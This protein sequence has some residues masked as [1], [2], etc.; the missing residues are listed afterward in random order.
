MT[1]GY[2]SGLLKRSTRFGSGWIRGKLLSSWKM[3]SRFALSLSLDSYTHLWLESY[4]YWGPDAKW[5]C[6]GDSVALFRS[7]AGITKCPCFLGGF[8]QG[9][10]RQAPKAG[11]VPC[12]YGTGV[13]ATKRGETNAKEVNIVLQYI[14]TQRISPWI[15]TESWITEKPGPQALTQG[16]R[17]TSP[18]HYLPMNLLI[19]LSS[20]K[21]PLHVRVRREKIMYL[22]RHI[23]LS[24]IVYNVGSRST[25]TQTLS[26]G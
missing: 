10:A 23:L 8:H 22:I 15:F 17:Q 25:Q 5:V 13:V 6:E 11:E 20:L 7:Q 2:A 9:G 21:N 12:R 14:R 3:W 19:L 4:F 18:I 26:E 16:S 1:P 24:E